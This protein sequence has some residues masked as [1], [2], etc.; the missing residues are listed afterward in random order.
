MSRG[1]V[2]RLED[3]AA[4]VQRVAHQRLVQQPALVGRADHAFAERRVV[5]LVH[6]AGSRTTSAVAP[7]VHG[8]RAAQQAQRAAGAAG[9][10]VA[11]ARGAGVGGEHAADVHRQRRVQ[12]RVDAALEVH[13]RQLLPAAA[14]RVGHVSAGCPAGCRR[15]SRRARAAVS[16]RRPGGLAMP[17]F[18]I[19]QPRRHGVG[20][21]RRSRRR[22]ACSRRC[23]PAAGPWSAPGGPAGCGTVD[24][25]A[26]SGL[27]AGVAGVVDHR[28]RDV[29][30]ALGAARQHE[31][32][33]RVAQAGLVAGSALRLQHRLHL[34]PGRWPR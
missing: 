20:Q 17:P 2:H 32:V 8:C 15:R 1:V 4:A 16:R 29:V 23:P 22:S 24:G 19:S 13:V 30:V 21:P 27:A 12:H 33:A 3:Q 11:A 10:V 7:G 18:C 31:A 9:V 14:R 28:Q 5:V 26:S 25:R 6:V 34:R